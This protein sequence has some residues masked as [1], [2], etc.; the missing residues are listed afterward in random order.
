MRY[1][2][3]SD[4][5]SNFEALM[6]VLRDIRTKSVDEIVCLGDV[7]GYGANPDEVVEVVREEV[8]YVVRG[9]H[10]DAVHDAGTYAVINHYARAAMDYTREVLSD[11]SKEWLKELPLT[12]KLG[13]ILFAHSSPSGPHDWRY[14]IS[15]S[16]ANME[17]GSFTERICFIG[18]THV[19]IVYRRELRDGE[20]R[21][22]INV[23]SVGQPR[24]GDNRASYG[25]IDTADY[26]Y[27]NYRIA[28]DYQL[29]GNKIIAA[30]L[31]IFLA[32]RLQKGK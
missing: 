27:E 4:I 19:P 5:H 14:I 6:T 10:D 1:A 16:E 17:L 28:Y 3:I 21:E 7:V 11:E 22:L 8:K 24:D 18:H 20:V 29:A 15:E 23:G 12:F 13:N 31:P 26:T 2:V 9:N 32:E 30:G 25:V